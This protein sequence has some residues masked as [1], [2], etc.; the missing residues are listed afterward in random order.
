MN[1]RKEIMTNGIISTFTS[2]LD[3]HKIHSLSDYEEGINEG[4]RIAAQK[5]REN[6]ER[7]ALACPDADRRVWQEGCIVIYEE[8]L[9]K[10]KKTSDPFDDY[11]TGIKKGLEEAGKIF[12]EFAKEYL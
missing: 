4:L 5:L 12:E 3:S 7:F 1:A 2:L 8:I 6:A 10:S 11:S 9:E